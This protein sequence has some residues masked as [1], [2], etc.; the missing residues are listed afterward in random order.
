MIKELFTVRFVAMN[1]SVKTF[2]GRDNQFTL[3]KFFHQFD[4]HM[5][6]A[7][8]KEPCDLVPFNQLHK[9]KMAFYSAS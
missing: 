4:A 3:E 9:R 6:F 2:D 5:M 7:F 8:G 1:N